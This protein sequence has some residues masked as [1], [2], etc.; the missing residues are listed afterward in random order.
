M[1]RSMHLGNPKVHTLLVEAKGFFFSENCFSSS[2]CD[3]CPGGEEFT[4]DDRCP[5]P[6]I[7]EEFMCKT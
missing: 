2:S 5:N 6:M 4:N 7:C 3:T 1:S